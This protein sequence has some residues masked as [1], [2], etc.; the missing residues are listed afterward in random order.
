MGHS[1]PGCQH[2]WQ[3][4]AVSC[5]CWCWCWGWGVQLTVPR[6]RH[7]PWTRVTGSE[8]AGPV[9]GCAARATSVRAPAGR[10]C[11]SHVATA[12][13]PVRVCVRMCVCARVPTRNEPSSAVSQPGAA[14]TAVQRNTT[15]G[16]WVR[17]HT[18]WWCSAVCGG[19]KGARGRGVYL[20]AGVCWGGAGAGARR[21][22][23]G[24]CWRQSI[25]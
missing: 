3:M 6:R 12:P 16:V 10:G 9:L 15:N 17:A 8:A 4:H 14:R 1:L 21:N 11:A 22:I 18:T 19:S 24:C 7:W 23:V 5:W 20:G 25:N 2:C 13:A